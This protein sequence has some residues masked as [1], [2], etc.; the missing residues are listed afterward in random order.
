MKKE[1]NPPPP[2]GVKRP[3]APPAPPSKRVS[4]H[5]RVV[6]RPMAAHDAR[7]EIYNEL[8]GYL[9]TIIHGYD[10]IEQREAR[11]IIARMYRLGG[12]PFGG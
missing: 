10:V 5:E 3:P 12:R 4:G 11:K 8:A 2:E 6:N 7:C 1:S 9:E